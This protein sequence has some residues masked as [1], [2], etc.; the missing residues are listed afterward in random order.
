MAFYTSFT[1]TSLFKSALF[2][3]AVTTFLILLISARRILLQ[4]KSP[5]PIQLYLDQFPPSRRHVP[6][7][8]PQFEKW[9]LQAEIPQSVLNSHA[10]P[11]TRTPDLSK[12][13]QYTP[14]GFSTQEI[15][16]L[17]RFPDYALL[18]GVPHPEPVSP[19]WDISRALFRPFRP[20][21]WN[22]HQHMALMKY[23]PN[24]WIELERNYAQT[25]SARQRLLQTHGARIMFE[26]G[27]SELAVRELS[28]MLLQFLAAR[29]PAHFS[30]SAC[31]TLFHNRLLGT[32]TD[33]LAT[34]PL[35]AIFANVPEDYALMLRSESDGLYYLR[36]AAVCSSVGWH[37]GQHRDSPV[38]SIHAEVPGAGRM[39]MS[40]DR[41][42]AKA[43]T[44][45]P[46]ARCSWSLED[47]EVLFAS[48]EAEAEEGREWKRGG[49]LRGGGKRS[50]DGAVAFNFKA[51]FTRLE[52]LRD[53]PYVPALL[54]KVLKEGNRELMEYKVEEHVKKVAMKALAEW[55]EEQ[56]ENGIVP[57]DWEVRTLDESPFFPG[58]ERKWRRQQG[59]E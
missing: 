9:A 11:T 2:L 20:F 40:M 37:V 50:W 21:R 49:F 19:A 43:A 5:T 45:A 44:N 17:G 30:L 53:E 6:A 16:A 15:R 58:W 46:V 32:T 54:H 34:P 18:S 3:G 25:M 51:T 48:P 10:L 39:A 56:V 8:L 57:A 33:L 22:Y 55:A 59:L 38:R 42:F 14:T 7:S 1:Y 23:S 13:N 12:D 31:N 27:G 24:W 28:E 47:R 41:W 36:A 26:S 52:E 4:S 35:R 29:Y